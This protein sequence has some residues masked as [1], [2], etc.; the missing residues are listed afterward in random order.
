[1]RR[2]GE[3]WLNEARR[4]QA[5]EADKL[6]TAQAARL[7]EEQARAEALEKDC[8]EKGARIAELDAR[9]ARFKQEVR[10]LLFD[11]HQLRE[12]PGSD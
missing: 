1:M 2:Q 9:V 11:A 10:P 7:A 12:D 5:A 3:T 6:A 4:W 8:A